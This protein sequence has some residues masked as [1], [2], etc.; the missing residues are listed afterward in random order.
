M[1]GASGSGEPTPLPFPAVRREGSSTACRAAEVQL[2]FRPDGEIRACCRNERSLGNVATDGV[3]TAWEGTRRSQLVD[4]LAR[5]DYSLGCTT[6][7]SEVATE[8]RAGSYPASFDEWSPD[9]TE[10]SGGEV[11][12]AILDFNVSIACNLQCVQCNGEQSSAIRLHR[13]HRPP[14]YLPYDERFFDEIRAFLPHARLA[15]FAGGEPFMASE[16]YRLWDLVSEVAPDLACT[17]ITNAT[18]WNDRVERAVR[19]VRMGFIFSIDGISKATYEAIRVGADFESVMANVE[20]LTERARS[21]G[22]PAT[23]NHCLMV[24]NHHEF[25]DILLWGEQRGLRIDVSVVR[26]PAHCSIVRLPQDR[27]AEV[28]RTLLDREPEVL[29]RLVLNRDSWV[30]ELRRIGTWATCDPELLHAMWG[31]SGRMVLMFKCEGRGPHDDEAARATVAEFADD[32]RVATFVAD[33][34]EFLVECLPG[35]AAMFGLGDGDVIGQPT[36]RL[37][38]LLASHLGAFADYRVVA[39]TPDRV[40]ATARFGDIE[41]RIAMVAMRDQRGW[42]NSARVLIGLRER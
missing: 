9:A 11:W 20:R 1:S 13:E 22:S 27:I 24:Q 18:I 5:H 23:V 14:L 26:D 35:S 38:D 25:A 37:N 8:G 42:A 2:F 30:S 15:R 10:R 16:N 39:E 41:A 31:I 7:G 17:V 32:G 3:A 36:V 19:S 29:D 28:H 40:D 34:H 4:A 6:C 33:S 12:P 21:A